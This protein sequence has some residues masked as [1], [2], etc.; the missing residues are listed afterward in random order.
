MLFKAIIFDLDG[1]LL[2]T[3]QDLADSCNQALL[4]EKATT[5]PVEDYKY[6]V[7]KGMDNLISTVIEKGELDP[8]LF[9]QIKANYIKEYAKRKNNK[10]KIYDGIMEVLEKLKDK[11]ISLNI[12]SNK[13]HFQTE[14]VVEY[15]F[16]DFKFDQIYG[17]KPEFKI[18]PNPESAK[19]LIKKIGLKPEDVLYIGDTNVDIL[20]AK[21]A[22]FT[23]V[24]VLWGFRKK[25]ELLE[26]G[27]DYIIKEPNDIYKIMVGDDNDFKS[28]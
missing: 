17:H 1:T 15:Y 3:I 28:K 25:A 19:D 20:T 18:K 5:Y 14:K 12:L 8:L 11:N 13:P 2:D 9:D 7:G 23:S 21:N 10:T 22:N 6:F 24:G 16:K 4:A 26:A 27:A